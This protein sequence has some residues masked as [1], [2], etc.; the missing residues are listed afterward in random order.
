MNAERWKLVDDVLQ[1]ALDRAPEERDAFLRRACAGDDT[2]ELEVR[3]LL[4][5][6]GRAGEFLESP[7][8]EVA[9][10]AMAHRRG[11]DA[12]GSAD[13]PIGRALSHY[14]IVGG[15]G[16]GGVWGPTGGAWYTRRRIRGSSAL[17]LSSFCPAN[18]PATRVP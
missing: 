6:D 13:F 16:G 11:V 8:L 18:P 15:L 3:S 9:A 4:T 10:K 1:S 14:R 2:L 7:A 5:S 12:D 17:S